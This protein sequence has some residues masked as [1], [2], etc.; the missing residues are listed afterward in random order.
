M[1]GT[2]KGTDRI[3]EHRADEP[4]QQRKR[5]RPRAPRLLVRDVEAAQEAWDCAVEGE[6]EASELDDKR[7]SGSGRVGAEGELVAVRVP[8][9][10]V[11]AMSE[12]GFSH[13]THQPRHLWRS[14]E[15]AHVL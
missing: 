12:Q 11:R 1:I 6:H 4:A 14:S 13:G 2:H 9:S 3:G 15:A 8:L 5:T 7:S 10:D